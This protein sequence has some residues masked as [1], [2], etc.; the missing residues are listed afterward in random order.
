[1]IDFN[2]QCFG[3]LLA[4]SE[5]GFTSLLMD[6]V[7]DDPGKKP[8]DGLIIIRVAGRTPTPLNVSKGNVV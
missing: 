7:E 4:S 2:M 8:I 3:S 5:G 6:L 1:M